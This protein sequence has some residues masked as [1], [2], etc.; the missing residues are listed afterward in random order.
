MDGKKIA[1]IG[2]GAIGTVYGKLLHEKYGSS[3]AVIAGGRRGEKLKAE[4]ATVNNET[5]YPQVIAPEETGFQADLILVCV[6]N[7]Q[8][9][10]AIEDMK[11]VVSSKTMILPLLNGV[12]A[13][14]R[15]LAA[16]PNNKVFYGLSIYIDAVRTPDGVVNTSNG[17]IQFGNAENTVPVPEVLEVKKI[18]T[19]AD[20][21]VQVLPDMIRAMWKKWMLNVGVNQVSAITG[22][23]YGKMAAI[24]SNQILFFEA[25]MEVVALARVA[26]VNLTEEDA[27]EFKELM[28]KFSPNGKTS[29]LQ[30]VEAKR[31]TE[32]DSF[33]GTVV[34]LGKKLNVPTPVNHVLY[35]IIKAIEQTY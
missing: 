28:S 23:N 9:E 29:M 20:I 34:E 17:L 32:V 7:Y 22:S 4:G 14:D 8:L 31:S 13:R 15:I 6:K 33:A 24:E 25:M 27:L 2:L 18:L 10:S 16:F 12:T 1:L 3:F 21:E 26:K 30:D 5:Y 35:H 11:N 19:D